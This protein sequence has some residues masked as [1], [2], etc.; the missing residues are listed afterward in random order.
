MMKIAP[1]EVNKFL[2]RASNVTN[3]GASK[4]VFLECGRLKRRFFF[5]GEEPA[6]V[7]LGGAPPRTE[8]AG[9]RR[10][11]PGSEPRALHTFHPTPRALH[12]LHHTPHT[13][14]AVGVFRQVTGP[15]PYTP[16]PTPC[17]LH[18]APCTLHPKPRMHASGYGLVDE[19]ARGPE[20]AVPVNP[21]PYTL[22]PT[23]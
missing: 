10:L 5:S 11:P 3:A 12:T 14:H 17:T 19:A 1:S 18:P 23:P 6:A 2:F 16:H 9:R 15:A 22:H 13:H 8:A 4:C 21:T 20:R 7:A